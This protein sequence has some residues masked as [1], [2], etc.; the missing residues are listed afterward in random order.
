MDKGNCQVIFEEMP[1]WLS[2]FTCSTADESLDLFAAVYHKVA[3]QEY[4]DLVAPQVAI[5]VKGQG[6]HC[7]K[8]GWIY[9]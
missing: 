5:L 8:I 7:V 1:D 9:N 2:V 4:V 3:N 6:G